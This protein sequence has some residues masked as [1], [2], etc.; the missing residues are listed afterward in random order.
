MLHQADGAPPMRVPRLVE[1]QRGRCAAGEKNGLE[2]A[3]TEGVV[4]RKGGFFLS[5]LARQRGEDRGDGF[6]TDLSGGDKSRSR[7][8]PIDAAVTVMERDS[9]ETPQCV[10]LKK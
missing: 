4:G 7:Q 9:V 6:G 10:L 5:M 3:P 1:L 2:M 8:Y